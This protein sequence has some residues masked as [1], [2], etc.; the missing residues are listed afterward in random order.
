MYASRGSS[1]HRLLGLAVLAVLLGIVAGVGILPAPRAT[2][3]GF[4]TVSVQKQLVLPNG[5]PVPNPSLSGYQFT[6][7]DNFGVEIV[8]PVT[9]AQGQTSIGVP[10]GNYFISEQMNPAVLEVRFSI[11][12]QQTAGFA[13][14]AGQTVSVTA[15]NTVSGSGSITVTKQIVDANGN[16]VVNADRSG[17]QFV[18]AGGPTNF[19]TTVT[20][21]VGGD[22]TVSNLAPGNYTVTESPRQGFTYVASAVD[23]V[24][25]ANGQPFPV[26]NNQ[27]RQVVFQNRAGGGAGGNS[28]VA[29]T[30]QIVD[31]SGNL[32]NNA[33]R[34]GFQF[35]V[36]CG[37]GAFTSSATTDGSGNASMS[38][39]PAGTCQ[40]S[41]T[42]RSGFTLV[43]IIPTGGV[44]IGNNG[45]FNV[46]AG[47][48]FNIQVRNRSGGGSGNTEAVPLTTGCTNVALTWP[49]GTAMTTVAAGVTPA[50][51]LESIFKL[52]AATG[53]FRGFS[54]SAPAFANDYNQ[55][56]A[57][58]EA[59][60]ICMRSPGTLNRPVR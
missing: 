23:G 6:L 20:T 59:V 29:I 38:N 8:M 39:V 46:A 43:S 4:G 28:T 22:V 44:D 34:S 14:A 16:V 37:S 32:V 2:A 50:G 51:V 47:Q 9:N 7:R 55:V 52:D 25:V 30:K 5:S 31:G 17:F 1:P 19:T 24:P 15:T 13:V 36:T 49:V 18:V 33:D 3:Q 40:I 35:T 26:A 48:T 54:P 11:G 53:R 60:F 10:P 12:G 21:P 56:E 57:S 58:L 42:P 27:N 45:S 41:E